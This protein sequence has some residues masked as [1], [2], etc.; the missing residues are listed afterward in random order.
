MLSTAPR[1]LEAKVA[2]FIKKKKLP[3]LPNMTLVKEDDLTLLLSSEHDDRLVRVRVGLYAPSL[4]FSPPPLSPSLCSCPSDH[5]YPP[6]L[7]FVASC[8]CVRRQP[9]CVERRCL[10]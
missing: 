10:W 6:S 1:Q 3:V 7:P 8:V 9:L 5:C 2:S 4:F